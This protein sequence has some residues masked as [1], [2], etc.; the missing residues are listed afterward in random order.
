MASCM[1]SIV[2]EIVPDLHFSILDIYYDVICPSIVPH[3]AQQ[4][5]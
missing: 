4:E 5:S 2:L 3:T 1:G